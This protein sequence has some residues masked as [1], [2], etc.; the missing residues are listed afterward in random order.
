MLCSCKYTSLNLVVRFQWFFNTVGPASGKTIWALF[1]SGQSDCQSG[2]KLILAVVGA[3]LRIYP[4]D[5]ADAPIRLSLVNFLLERRSRCFRDCEMSLC[6]SCGS[7]LNESSAR[8]LTAQHAYD[9]RP[10]LEETE[11]EIL[12]MQELLHRLKQKHASLRKAVNDRHSPVLR[13]PTK[14]STEI[15]LHCLPDINLPITANSW[16]TYFGSICRTWRDLIWSTPQICSI[17]SVDLS[18]GMPIEHLKEWFI[19]S[20]PLPLSIQLYG[21]P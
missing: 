19:R 5:G 16:R 14:L 9:P 13:L 17:V 10:Q 1:L 21:I 20:D 12:R 3:S 4:S 6:A 15:I 8:S 7:R 18:S 11:L 2:V